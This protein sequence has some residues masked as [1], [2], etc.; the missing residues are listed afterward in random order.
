MSSPKID[1]LLHDR[2]L[3]PQG[4]V[5]MSESFG[6]MDVSECFK[7]LFAHNSPKNTQIHQNREELFEEL[8]GESGIGATNHGLTPDQARV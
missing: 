1:N 7:N 2:S 5:G 8:F 6:D 3:T 4:G